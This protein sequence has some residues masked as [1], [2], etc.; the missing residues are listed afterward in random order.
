MNYINKLFIAGIVLLF[1]A[2]GNDQNSS[3]GDASSNVVEVDL[4]GNDKMQFNLKSIVASE[5]DVIKVNFMN[6]GKM[7]KNVMGHNFVLLKEGVNVAD[8]ASKAL[9]AKEN[10]Y[11]PEDELSNIIVH[12]KMLGPG[13]NEIITFNAPSK[14]IYKFVCSFPGHYITMQGDLIIK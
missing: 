12:S 3:S 4:T 9:K 14:G 13:E 10:D 7:P 5:G 1:L 11:I 6:I 2:C 8:F